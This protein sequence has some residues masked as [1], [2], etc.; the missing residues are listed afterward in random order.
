MVMLAMLLRLHESLETARTDLSVSLGNR[1]SRVRRTASP[2]D[3][4]TPNYVID[5]VI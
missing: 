4:R 2:L 1:R 5:H 3:R